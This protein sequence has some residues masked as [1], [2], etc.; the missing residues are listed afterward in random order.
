MQ[1]I[2]FRCVASN[3]FR[4]IVKSEYPHSLSSWQSLSERGRIMHRAEV[5]LAGRR[6][7]WLGVGRKGFAGRGGRGEWWQGPL[8]P[9]HSDKKG[10]CAFPLGPL[11][12][13][14][15]VKLFS[16]QLLTIHYEFA[17]GLG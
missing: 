9:N 11:F 8:L 3:P 12:V 10:G 14:R 2:A 17:L 16:Y 15:T 4:S 6:V 1:G 7:R 13:N 5:G